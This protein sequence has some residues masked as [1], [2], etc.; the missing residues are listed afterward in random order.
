MLR[1]CNSSACFYLRPPLR[2]PSPKT[3]PRRRAREGERGAEARAH[4]QLYRGDARSECA[5][6]RGV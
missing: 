1:L 4:M 5:L 3:D 6:Q 2:P